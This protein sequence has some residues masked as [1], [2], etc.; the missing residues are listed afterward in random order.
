VLGLAPA[1]EA[2]TWNVKCDED[3]LIEAIENAN[4]NGVS[5]VITLKKG[6]TY[7]FDWAADDKSA[8]RHIENDTGN[9]SVDLVIK[10][11][12]ARLV[13]DDDEDSQDFRLLTIGDEA[14]VVINDLTVSGGYVTDP[15]GGGIEVGPGAS[16]TATNLKVLDNTVYS[17]GDAADD[18]I[19]AGIN[20]D[21]CDELALNK[22]TV[23]DNV[24]TTI[25]LAGSAASAGGG[26]TAFTS[27]G[28]VE[29]TLLKTSVKGNEAR[30][31]GT[32]GA[33][34][35]GGGILCD[36][37]SAL[38]LDDSKVTKN[39]AEGR[40][41][42]SDTFGGGVMAFAT[43]TVT[44]TDTVVSGNTADAEDGLAG[45][46]GLH[47]LTE[48][49]TITESEI[50]K[51]T[52][53]A[54]GNGSAAWGGGI[55]QVG[56]TL[57]VDSGDEDESSEISDNKAI[58]TGF[59]SSAQGGG[60][61]VAA[62]EADFNFTEFEGN[63]VEA[64]DGIARGGGL[65][66]GGSVVTLNQ[67]EVEENEADGMVEEGGGVYVEPCADFDPDLSD[68]EDNKPDDVFAEGDCV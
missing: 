37:C 49:T 44:L 22:S 54:T 60:Y 67:A 41:S 46:G 21:E 13:R 6:C 42:D 5:D 45:G 33:Q 10:G 31:R 68:F 58:A 57:T 59:G 39:L 7:E 50:T 17:V 8:T 52:V 12:G 9:E 2:A 19:G 64:P 11:N 15:S 62:D 24:A 65:Y 53:R 43:D 47:L 27:Q 34:T 63:E 4:G 61:Y 48:T 66:V 32:I 14:N 3:K 38:V 28:T 56:G 25:N 23:A 36:T 29:V 51:N 55:R 30:A 26:I 18:S 1:A 20:C 35:W 16:L 40:S